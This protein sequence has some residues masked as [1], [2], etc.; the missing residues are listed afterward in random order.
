VTRWRVDVDPLN[1][2]TLGR[3]D[4]DTKL[5]RGPLKVN[6]F[7]LGVRTAESPD[8]VGHLLRNSGSGLGRWLRSLGK[9]F[10]G[11]AFWIVDLD[12]DGDLR[13]LIPLFLRF[14]DCPETIL[15][16]YQSCP[17][18]ANRTRFPVARACSVVTEQR[19]D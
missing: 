2:L 1:A 3:L 5:T 16:P 9:H 8:P 19:T 4:T 10:D 7:V 11:T 12:R 13:H 14:Q 15:E 17:R 6:A 18:I